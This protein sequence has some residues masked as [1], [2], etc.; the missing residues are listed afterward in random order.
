MLVKQT[1]RGASTLK[2]EGKIPPSVVMLGKP[3]K[4][5]FFSGL[6]TMSEAGPLRFFFK[7][8]IIH[9]LL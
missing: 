8:I 5:S 9:I 6:T 2:T 3:P 4:S 1:K 7:S